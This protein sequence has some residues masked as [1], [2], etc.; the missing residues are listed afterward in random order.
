MMRIMSE[1]ICMRRR[2]RKTSTGLLPRKLLLSHKG[3]VRQS[4]LRYNAHAVL[5]T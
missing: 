2:R 1:N 4:V 5:E 3:L